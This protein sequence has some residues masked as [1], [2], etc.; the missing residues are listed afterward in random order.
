MEQARAAREA[1]M[2]RRPGYSV[3]RTIKRSKFKDEFKNLNVEGLRKAGFPEHP[4]LKLANR[5]SIAVLPFTNMSDDKGQEYF[6]DGITEDIITDLSKLSKLFVVARDS[7]F[8]YKGRSVDP[9][10]VGRALRAK[11]LLEGSVRRAGDQLRINVQLIDA[12]TG[13]QIWAER[14]DGKLADTFAL[15]DKVTGRIIEAMAIKLGAKERKKLADHGTNNFAAHDAFLKGQSFA[16]QYTSEGFAQ[17]IQP[18]EQALVLDPQYSRAAKAITQ[19][20]YIKEN[21]GLR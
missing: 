13:G 6:A 4:P 14:Y 2:K 18:F 12:E 3:Q 17:A 11:Y 8:R 20:R 10:Q 15:Q 21:S 9:R 5:P 19:M 1:F 16:R 7:S